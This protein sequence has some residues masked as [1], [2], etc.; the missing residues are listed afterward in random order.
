MYRKTDDEPKN[1]TLMRSNGG[2]ISKILN[3]CAV[4]DDRE[5]EQPQK[6]KRLE[7]IRKKT[8]FDCSKVLK[9]NISRE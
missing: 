4:T 8:I 9:C 7:Y 2:N 3:C 5:L 1:T 6:K